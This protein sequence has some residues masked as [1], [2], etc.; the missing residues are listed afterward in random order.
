MTMNAITTAQ[1]TRT[2]AIGPVLQ[3]QSFQELA[4]FAEMAAASDLM[5]RDYK[6]KPGNIMI[7]VQMGSELGL[8]P[9]QAIQNVAVINGRPSVWGDALL[10][11]VR[12][13]PKCQDVHEV[14]AGDGD[15]RTATCTVKRLGS[16]D[17]VRTFSVGDAKKASLWGKQGPWQ[18]YPDRMLQMRAR[19]FALRDA[20]PDVLRGLVT[21]EEA[22]DT[23]VDTFRGVTLDSVAAPTT[24]TARQA[25]PPSPVD[26]VRQRLATCNDKECVERVAEGWRKTAAKANEAGRPFSEIMVQDVMD[27]LADAYGRFVDGAAQNEPIDDTDEMPS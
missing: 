23:P 9:M 21:A 4:R 3:P 6:G 22:A 15:G 1:P 24:D 8:S 17:V 19:G 13:N 18:Q 26:V 5:P 27:L 11:L 12:N 14:I 10:G 20:F 16:T 7:A 2:R 25:P